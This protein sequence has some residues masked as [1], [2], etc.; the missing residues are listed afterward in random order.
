M[1]QVC[2]QAPLV[3]I[4][5]G[6]DLPRT[7]KPC[8]VAPWHSQ[9]QGRKV[10]L[11][12]G[13]LHI[14]KGLDELVTAV[15]NLKKSDPS[16]SKEW[17]VVIAGWGIDGYPE[18]VARAVSDAGLDESIFMAGPVFGDIKRA[19][20]QHAT[21][22]ILPS[23]S[24]GLPMSILEAWSYGL[25]VVMTDAC[26]L[27]EGFAAD[28]AIHITTEPTNIQQGLK[29]LTQENQLSLQAMGQRGRALVERS[30]T[31]DSVAERCDHVYR[32]CLGGGTPPE[33]IIMPG[34]P[35]G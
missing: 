16:W 4:P 19:C 3:I 8:P 14:K 32:W 20:M 18:N 13:R 24:E 26:N 9:V 22:F 23:H 11:F 27:P 35:L 25:P 12:L 10:L 1:R 17:L 29:R 2:P 30:F 33:C 28:A 31:W 6:I 15:A 21:A 34:K 5:N 7:D